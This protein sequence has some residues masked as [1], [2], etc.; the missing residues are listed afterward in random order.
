M[1][2]RNKIR[3]ILVL[4]AGTLL[5]LLA[6]GFFLINKDNTINQNPIQEETEGTWKYADDFTS[7]KNCRCLEREIKEC[8]LEGFEYIPERKIC[9]NEN[10]VTNPI[11]R[12]SKYECSGE[13]YSFNFDIELW[14]K[15]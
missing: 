14:E 9:K 4:G 15:N 10:L 6:L 3:K 5:I 7:D 11:S 13:V 2:K 12:C 8:F 1:K